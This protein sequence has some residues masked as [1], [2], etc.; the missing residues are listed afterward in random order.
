M[1]GRHALATTPLTARYQRSRT[2]QIDTN[3]GSKNDVLQD[4]GFT[5]SV[6]ALFDHEFEKLGA[7]GRYRLLRAAWSLLFLSRVEDSDNLV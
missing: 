1:R 4:L 7:R 2:F 6:G 3:H 5:P